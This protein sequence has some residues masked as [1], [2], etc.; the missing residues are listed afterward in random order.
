MMRSLQ[1]IQNVIRCINDE[2]DKVKSLKNRY[3]N[4]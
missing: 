1:C 2:P 3:Q 4:N